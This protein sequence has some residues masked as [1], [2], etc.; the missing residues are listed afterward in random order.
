[1]NKKNLKTIGLISAIGYGAYQTYKILS[2]DEK[3]KDLKDKVVVITGASSG[4]GK[5]YAIDFA[6]YG[7]KIVLAARRT[8]KLEELANELKEKYNTETL[9]VTTD[10]S[11][12]EDS[13]N[14]IEKAL[15]KFGAID[16]LINNAGISTF[17]FFHNDDTEN[18]RKVM[19]VNYW[20]MIYCTH[21]VLPSMIKNKSGKII[22]ISSTSSRIAIP[23]MANYSATKHAMNG[24]S[25]ALRLEVAKYGIKVITICPTVTKTDIVSTSINSSSVKFNP[26]N[27]FGMTVERVSKETINAILDNKSELIIG[28]GE[29]LSV[30]VNKNLPSLVGLVLKNTSKFLFKE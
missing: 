25:D 6:K 22:N 24:F 28:L 12:K 8:E 18:L 4:I 30:A 13:N 17:S 14:L 29:K 3:I 26:D 11:K 15:E 9:V 19:D 10:V 7:S 20:G 5:A 23:G 16:I 21:A 27:Y 1:M 2:R